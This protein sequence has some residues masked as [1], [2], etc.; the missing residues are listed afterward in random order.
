MAENLMFKARINMWP[1]ARIAMA[2]G[3]WERAPR[4]V[5]LWAL[6]VFLYLA[7]HRKAFRITIG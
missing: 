4:T 2:I 3:L 1:L 7:E 6:A 5:R